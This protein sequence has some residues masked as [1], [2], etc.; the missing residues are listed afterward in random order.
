MHGQH[1]R[2]HRAPQDHP[3]DRHHRVLQRL[4]AVRLRDRIRGTAGGTQLVAENAGVWVTEVPGFLQ[5]Y[6]VYLNPV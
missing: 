1:F 5:F 4:G 6:V 3:G 2:P